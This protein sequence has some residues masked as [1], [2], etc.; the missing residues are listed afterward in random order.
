[1]SFDDT[2]NHWA[3][4]SIK[5]AAE[6]GL[7]AGYEDGSFKPE[8]PIT[9]AETATI[10]MRLYDRTKESFEDLI[11]RAEPAVLTVSNLSTGAIGS[12]TSIGRGFVLTNAHVVLD[13]QGKT[14]W[15]YGVRWDS[16]SYDE[17]ANLKYAEG[18]CVFVAPE[19]DLAIIR[20]DIGP[21]R[22]AMPVL[23]LGDAGLVRRG[24][25]C[26]VIG[27]PVG[28]AGT[29]TSG[30]VSYV[31][32]KLSYEVAPGVKA[33][34]A[35]LIQ[36]DAPINPGNSGGALVNRKGELIGVPSVKLSEVGIE[37]LGF[38]IG[39]ETIRQVVTNA[40][41]S[42]ALAVAYRKDLVAALSSY[43]VA[44]A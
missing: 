16:W 33:S 43:R 5:R 14:T 6:L 38:A 40:D 15:H 17:T 31:G 26:A 27:S 25:P 19:V 36:T 12:G 44:L 42:G 18:P 3:E 28:L 22:D 30:I 21:G 29:V 24:M 23:V 10:A 35:D 37:G 41:K 13:D 1:M 34:F 7:L 8:Q 11:A 20:V 32:R 39:L 2:K 4:E 9:R